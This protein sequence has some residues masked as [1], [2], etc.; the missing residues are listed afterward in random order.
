MLSLIRVAMVKA[1][2]HTVK[3]LMKTVVSTHSQ[4]EITTPRRVEAL[5]LW[6]LHFNLWLAGFLL[7]VVAVWGFHQRPWFICRLNSEGQLDVLQDTYS[8]DYILW[9]VFCTFYSLDLLSKCI[10]FTEFYS[11]LIIS[12]L[13]SPSAALRST[14]TSISPQFDVIFK[15]SHWVYLVLPIYSCV[16]DMTLIHIS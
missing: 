6:S 2:L 11:I 14:R 12:I 5:P 4:E 9:D 7:R 1:I 10:L 8:I 15:I 16:W 13:V 3:N